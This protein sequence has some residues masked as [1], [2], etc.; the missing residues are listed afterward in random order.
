MEQW[1]E[2]CSQAGENITVE[3]LECNP[4]VPDTATDSSNP[5]WMAFSSALDE[6]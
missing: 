4:K 3:V 5:F 6:M 1:Q 2:V